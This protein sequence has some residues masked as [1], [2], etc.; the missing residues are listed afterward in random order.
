MHN[1]DGLL[2]V[3]G[4]GAGKT[5][6]AVTVAECYLD[7]FPNS[8]VVVVAPASLVPN[9]RKEMKTYGEIR[10]PEKYELYSD[11]KFTRL[12]VSGHPVNVKGKL[13]I[14]DEAHNIRSTASDRIGR[15]L[16]EEECE[17]R[18]PNCKKSSAVLTAA[19]QAKKRL[20]LTATPFYNSMND[21]RNLINAVYGRPI[22]GTYQEY[23]DGM[24]RGMENYIEISTERNHTGQ[25]TED[26]L[27]IVKHYLKNKVSYITIK[28]TDYAE[29]REHYVDVP[30]T[31]EYYKKYI[32]F[33]KKTPG[34][35]IE[36]LKA[37]GRFLLTARQAVNK[38]GPGY[39]SQKVEASIKYIK[40]KKGKVY[41]SIIYTNFI[42]FGVSPIEDVLDQEGIKYKTIS[43]KITAKNKQKIVNEFNS[44]KFNVLIITKAGGEGLDLKGVRKVIV[45]DPVWSDASITQIIGRAIRYRAHAHLK[46]SKRYVDIY[47]MS[48]VPP[49]GAKGIPTGDQRLYEIIKRK[50]EINKK[51]IKILRKDCME[52]KYCEDVYKQ[53]SR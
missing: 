30:L 10:D 14:V 3:H 26:A 17:T 48:A 43:G 47:Y 4:T 6:T 16:T 38:A 7:E 45:L 36:G 49:P 11:V 24:V 37:T 53:Y 9:F 39:Y 52:R 8:G 12:A 46:K 13:L 40:N 28:G 27:E 5:L 33:I 32:Q 35:Q 2:V 21:F 19:Y 1:N 22:L 51:V 23:K 25:N 18:D 34:V 41:K 15:E 31:P 50:G 42:G 20:L 29:K 44:D